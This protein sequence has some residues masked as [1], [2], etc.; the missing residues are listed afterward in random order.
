[1]TK[2]L[3]GDD[4]EELKDYFYPKTGYKL[5]DGS[6]E[7]L[8][9]PSMVKDG[10]KALELYK[11]D[12]I[13]LG[14]IKFAGSKGSPLFT[15]L[16]DLTLNKDF[17]GVEVRN[18]EDPQYLQAKQN[19]EYLLK[20]I[21][22]ISYTSSKKRTLMDPNMSLVQKSLPYLGF[23]RA[24]AYITNTESKKIINRLLNKKFGERVK[25]RE[26]FEKSKAKTELRQKIYYGNATPEEILEA[27]KNGVIK[28]KE[29]EEFI[30]ES[31]MD[32][33]V[34]NF[35]NL[36]NKEQEKVWMKINAEEKLRYILYLKEKLLQKL[37]DEKIL[38]KKINW[39]NYD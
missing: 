13:V 8:T 36:T 5:P 17:Y 14:A 2:L 33:D 12:G 9:I 30:E 15:V 22:P 32:A 27:I 38:G 28:S 1:M 19:M 6:D 35:K 10:F 24:P 23:S 31:K 25:T 39:I 7:R 18:T 29:W 4:P 26:E 11:E 20:A 16:H 3:S 34:R 21:T 37:S